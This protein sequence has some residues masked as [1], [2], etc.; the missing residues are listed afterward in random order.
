MSLLK[1]KSYLKRQNRAV[2][3][4]TRSQ[5]REKRADDPPQDQILSEKPE[6][7]DALQRTSNFPPEFYDNL[8]KVW[9]T[10]RALQEHNRRNENLDPSKPVARLVRSRKAKLAALA[11]LGVPDLAL[12]ATS[13]GPDLSG[14]RG[15]PEPTISPTM[16]ST[17]LEVMSKAFS[18][19]SRRTQP[20]KA[21]SGSFQCK[22]SS[23][24]DANF[25]QFCIDHNLYPPAYKFP[26]GSRPLKPKN[27]EEVRQTLKVPRGSL[28]PSVVP[29][30]AFEDFQDKNATRSEGTVMRNVVPLIAGDA[31]IPN[32]GHLPFTNLASITEDTTVNPMPDFFDGAHPEAV[33]R[34]VKEDLDKIIIPTKKGGVPIAPN[35][36]LE[37]KSPGG[38]IEAAVGQAVL[39]GAHGAII[40][41]A[42]QNYLVDEPVYDGN[43]YAFTSTLIDGYLKLYA[44]HL[45]APAKSGQRPGYH[46]TLLKAYAL[47]DDEVY[48]EG[49]GAFRNL[50]MRAKEDRDRFIEIAN[51]RARSKYKRQ[52]YENIERN[53]TGTTKE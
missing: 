52:K 33:D 41:H 3:F 39:D 22:R 45:T 24:Y 12:F 14:L 47:S 30:T 36:F 40:M 28:S 53:L 26:D 18:T 25:R 50:R 23:A 1:T 35:F 6:A 10:R 7:S 9:L 11:R 46:S 19:D 29:E 32:E 20:I 48:P 5:N 49:R 38:N 37:A 2:C 13:G 34:R 21:T 42:L 27:F 17:S 44:H 15:Y 51:A 4:L 8:S 43:A 31:D 16:A